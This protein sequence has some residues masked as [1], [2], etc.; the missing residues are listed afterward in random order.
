M[1]NSR[2]EIQH[3]INEVEEE[4]RGCF[5]RLFDIIEN[6]IPEGFQSQMGYGMP[7]WVVPFSR[8]TSGYHCD[9]KLPLPFLNIAAQK[10]HISIYHMGIY[11]DRE[12]LD[13]FQ[14][15]YPKHCKLKLNMGRSCIRFRNPKK[16]PFELVGELVSR[17]TVDEWIELYKRNLKS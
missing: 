5:Q 10:K 15:E 17:M 14:S 11:A 3:Y 4:R 12:L 7:G 13:W 2:I 1:S 8:F 9:P 16:I 6:N